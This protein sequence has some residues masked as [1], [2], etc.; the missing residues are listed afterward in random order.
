MGRVWT[1]GVTTPGGK[2]TAPTP[3]KV[4]WNGQA[5]LVQASPP[6]SG[7]ALRSTT[8]IPRLRSPVPAG[9]LPHGLT[10][11]LYFTQS[12]QKCEAE[13]FL[14]MTIVM[15]CS[16]HCPTPTMFPAER[17]PGEPSVPRA[18][19]PSPVRE[20][21]GRA[22][23]TPHPGSP[24]MGVHL[25]RAPRTMGTGDETR[26][27]EMW[28]SASSH[29]DIP[30]HLS[31]PARPRFPSSRLSTRNTDKAQLFQSQAWSWDNPPLPLLTPKVSQID[32]CLP[33][34]RKAF[35]QHCQQQPSPP[36]HGDCCCTSFQPE[37]WAWL[38]EETVPACRAPYGTRYLQRG[39]AGGSRT[40]HRQASCENRKKLSWT[41]G[42]TWGGRVKG[43]VS[44]RA[45]GTVLGQGRAQP[46][47]P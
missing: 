45:R 29:P 40:S 13:N 28:G 30:A 11:Q 1:R 39:R 22:R 26:G 42:S 34:K 15:P 31:Q 18:L 44:S 25:A 8:K 3:C 2:D 6:S 38:R 33:G 21:P 47:P 32:F 20:R 17:Q 23:R 35:V 10:V 12:S 36:Q 19:Q 14:R 4:V 46:R 7:W 37:P 27:N 43:C 16:R 5:E 41:C 24:Q 9:P